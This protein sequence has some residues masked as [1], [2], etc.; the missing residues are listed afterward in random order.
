MMTVL[1][2]CADAEGSEA[3]RLLETSLLTLRVYSQESIMPI[4]DWSRVNAGIF[5]HFHQNWM[6]QLA[7]AL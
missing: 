3:H 1:C 6:I 2:G 4:H 5:H 7:H